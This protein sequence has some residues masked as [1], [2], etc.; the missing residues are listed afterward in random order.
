MNPR[1][2]QNII[3]LLAITVLIIGGLSSFYVHANQV[4]QLQNKDSIIINDQSFEIPALF[5]MFS[6]ITIETDDGNRTGVVISKILLYTGVDCPTC[7]SYILKASD[8]Y[9]QTVDWEDMQKGILT[10]EKRSYF[11]HLAHAFW[12][13]NIVEIE[14]KEL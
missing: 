12:V 8:G 4:N 9:Q 3:P 6:T 13:Q 10:V 7:R 2:K 1:G 11:P 14:V 5:D